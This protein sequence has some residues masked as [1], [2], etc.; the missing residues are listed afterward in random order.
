[1]RGIKFVI[2]PSARN[3]NKI[4]FLAGML[5]GGV[6]NSTC[7]YRGVTGKTNERMLKEVKRTGSIKLWLPDKKNRDEAYKFCQ[8]IFHPSGLIKDI[9][10]IRRR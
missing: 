5:R 3:M 2:S 8:S 4:R 6:L 1:M 9:R 10:R 7:G